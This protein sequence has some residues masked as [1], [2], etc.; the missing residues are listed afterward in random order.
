MG[1]RW[2]AWGLGVRSVWVWLFPGWS[3]VYAIDAMK[4][5]GGVLGGERRRRGIWKGLV[6]HMPLRWGWGS[7]D[8]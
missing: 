6:P 5:V 1:W 2:M 3:G 8:L 4:M 7:G